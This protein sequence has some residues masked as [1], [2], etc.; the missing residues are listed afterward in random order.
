MCGR[1]A[2]GVDSDQLTQLFELVHAAPVVANW[3]V[4]PQSVAPVVL[5]SAKRG[6]RTLEPLTWGF[7]PSADPMNEGKRQSSQKHGDARQYYINAR[8]ETVSA[9]RS[10]R[11]QL[12]TRRCVVPA[13][14]FYEWQ[15]TGAAGRGDRL[16]HYVRRQ[17]ESAL[18][19]AGLWNR[20][21]GEDGAPHHSFLVLTQ[22]MP[23]ALGYIHKRAPIDL[24]RDGMR[25]W[26]DPTAEPSHALAGARSTAVTNWRAHRVGMDVNDGRARGIG[27]CYPIAEET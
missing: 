27:L 18:M 4:T 21:R 8:A 16:P 14:G 9:L 1:Y 13:S 5:S 11:Y 15:R 7:R 25:R 19:L 20:T 24:S 3:N 22:P 12:Q 6:G 2:L 10:F 23:D 26:L 17:D